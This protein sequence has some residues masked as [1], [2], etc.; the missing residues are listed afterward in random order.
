MLTVTKF[1]SATAAAQGTL[2][3]MLKD[4]QLMV[5][6]KRK[7]AIGLC[8][9]LTVAPLLGSFF[10]FSTVGQYIGNLTPYIHLTISQVD[11]L[12]FGDTLGAL[13]A[14]AIF[15]VGLISFIIFVLTKFK[16]TSGLILLL[17][18]TM[19][20]CGLRIFGSIVIT[21]ISFSKKTL[22]LLQ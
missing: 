2:C 9:F 6:T 16:K 4:K 14:I 15:L 11:G 18:M 22:I 21:V 8:L 17:S 12:P 3:P 20:Y 7:I 19:I 13:F 10:S 5:T 1:F